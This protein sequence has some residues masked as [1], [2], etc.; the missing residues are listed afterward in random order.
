MYPRPRTVQPAG[1]VGSN[2]GAWVVDEG[3][4]LCDGASNGIV[5]IAALTCERSLIVGPQAMLCRSIGAIV[6]LM[7]G[8]PYSPLAVNASLV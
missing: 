2:T 4:F 3:V 8:R 7:G 6:D 1:T 5:Q